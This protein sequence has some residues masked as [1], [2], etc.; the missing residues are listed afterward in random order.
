M[1][2]TYQTYRD[3]FFSQY[4]DLYQ[5]IINQN[6]EFITNQSTYA[7]NQYDT[8]IETIIFSLQSI[9]ASNIIDIIKTQLNF[10]KILPCIIPANLIANLSSSQYH[11]YQTITNYLG[12][13]DT[14]HYPYFFITGSAG[15]GKSFMIHAF[16]EYFQ[17]IH[18]NYLLM[19]ST[20]IAALNVDEQVWNTL[21]QKLS[22][23]IQLPQ[24]NTTLNTTHIVGYRETAELINRIICA[25]IPTHEDKILISESIDIVDGQIY[26]SN[27]RNCDFANNTNLTNTIRIQPEARVMFLNNSQYKHG[28][29]NG[30]IINTSFTKYTHNFYLNGSPASRTQYPI[31]NAFALTVHKTQGLTIPDVSLNLNNQIFEYGQAYV[32]LSRCT[33]WEHVKIQ[34]LDRNAFIINQSMINEYERLESK[35]RQPL[36]LNN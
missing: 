25:S 18:R 19:A 4:P 10:L 5:S 16:L 29:A 34:S 6:S 17:R 36:P 28:I 9:L 7:L 26:S 30:A 8:I 3:H 14:S 21:S 11:C 15:N 24:P 33:K 2:G 35:S 1:L 20:G 32:A 22:E 23:T 27:S 12:K 13:R 31:Q